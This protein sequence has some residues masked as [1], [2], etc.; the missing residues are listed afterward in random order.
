MRG[1][2]VYNEQKVEKGQ[3]SV[4]ITSNFGGEVER[5]SIAP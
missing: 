5:M 4:F 3:A 2:L 1:I